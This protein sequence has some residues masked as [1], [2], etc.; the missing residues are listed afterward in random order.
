MITMTKVFDVMDNRLHHYY[1]EYSSVEDT[2][3]L[4]ADNIVFVEAP[5][6]C[7]EGY[8]YLPEAEGDDRFIR[9]MLPEGWVYDQYGNPT[10]PES[11][12]ETERTILKEQAD[13]DLFEALNAIFDGDTSHDWTSWANALKAFKTAVDATVN[14]PN[15]PNEVE[16][17][18]YPTRPWEQE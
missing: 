1:P 7:Y 11:F 5:D 9:P 3:G 13:K 17:P 14:D 4:Y 16:Y 18:E 15:Y 10:N 8:G 2:I 6:W 12:R